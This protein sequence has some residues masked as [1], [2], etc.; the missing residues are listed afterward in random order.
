VIEVAYHRSSSIEETIQLLQVSGGKLIAGGTDILP[1]IRKGNLAISTIIDLSSIKSLR[2][3]RDV[4]EWIEVG[5]IT[6]HRMIECSGLIHEYAPAFEAAAHSI[7]CPQTRARGTLG[8]NLVNAS[9]AG[10]TAPPLLALDAELIIQNSNGVRSVPLI[11]FF[12]GPGKTV[13]SDLDILTRVRFMKPVGRWG[14]AFLKLG[15]RK[16]MAISVASVAAYVHL[17][18]E[19]RMDAVRVAYGSLAPTPIRAI[20]VEKTLLGQYPAMELFRIAG[21]KCTGDIS[22]I[23]DLRASAEYR[24]KAAKV[25]TIRALQI[26][27]EQA[28]ERITP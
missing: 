27:F 16:G 14:S 7:G 6:P 22:P 23:T 11:D 28:R 25:L 24:L 18:S 5:A 4:D 2:Y 20:S 19:G 26:A 12:R 21:E 10:D 8:G 1:R 3:I 13:M 15:K 17:D 9:P